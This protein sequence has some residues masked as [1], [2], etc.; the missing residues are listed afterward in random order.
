MDPFICESAAD[1]ACCV[2]AEAP[3][4]EVGVAVL[5]AEAYDRTG[6]CAGTAPDDG[7]DVAGVLEES[8]V[9]GAALAEFCELAG[10]ALVMSGSGV[11]E[12]SVSVRYR[13]TVRCQM[14]RRRITARGGAEW[15]ERRRGGQRLSFEAEMEKPAATGV[16]CR[17]DEFPSRFCARCEK[18]FCFWLG[19]CLGTNRHNFDSSVVRSMM[20]ELQV[21]RLEKSKG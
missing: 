15:V 20:E 10:S 19:I 8:R 3:A 5:V 11:V 2:G 6:S 13:A 7:A 9:C 4:E 16:G 14:S 18:L 1:F 21:G 17:R 12:S